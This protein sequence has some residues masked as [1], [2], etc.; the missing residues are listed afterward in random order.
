[1]ALFR[2]RTTPR[3]PVADLDRAAVEVD[4]RSLA[5]SEA[6]VAAR[7]EGGGLSVTVYHP[8]LADLLDEPRAQ[9]SYE[10][11]VAA[12]G[13]DALRRTVVQVSP[14]THPP[15]DPF[16]LGPLRA[17]VRSLGVAVDPTD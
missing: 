7:V 12:L 1:M 3:P 5:L 17:F 9:A 11:L 4:G 13:E 10:I 2:R 16:G 15:I 8:A 6:L 14:A